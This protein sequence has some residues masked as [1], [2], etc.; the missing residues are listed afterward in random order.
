MDEV[1]INEAGGKQSKVRGD[2]TLIPPEVLR[3]VAVVLGQGAARYGKSNWMLI[4][5]TEHINH[6]LAHINKHLMDDE[7]EPHLTNAICRLMF[8]SHMEKYHDGSK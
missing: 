1:I 6:A 3:D 8:A 7:S 2:F 4:P 5:A